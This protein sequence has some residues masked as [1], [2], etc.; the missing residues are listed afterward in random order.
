MLPPLAR[1]EPRIDREPLTVCAYLLSAHR[2]HRGV[3]LAIRPESVQ[4]LDDELAH[5]PELRLAEAPRR[6]GGAA[7]PDAGGHRR[8]LG[9]EGNA[10][11]VAG[12][13]GALECLLGDAAGQLFRPEID[14]HQVAVGTTRNDR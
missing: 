13:A 6:R 7:E 14:Q 3:R 9:I 10:V 8:L 11:L 1:S 5:L 12:D 4:H 2:L